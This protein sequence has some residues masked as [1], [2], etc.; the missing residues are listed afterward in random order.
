MT[1]DDMNTLLYLATCSQQDESEHAYQPELS[2][3]DANTKLPFTAVIRLILWV[4]L[5]FSS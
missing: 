2:S 4:L 3:S 5:P 1:R